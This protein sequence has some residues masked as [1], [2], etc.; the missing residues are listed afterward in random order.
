VAEHTVNLDKKTPL[1][2]TIVARGERRFSL[3]IRCVLNVKDRDSRL[4]TA[5]AMEEQRRKDKWWLASRGEEGIVESNRDP[6]TVVA[7]P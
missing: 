4:M 7:K 6:Q 3:T 2:E 1:A 5:E